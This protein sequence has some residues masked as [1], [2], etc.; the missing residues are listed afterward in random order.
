LDSMLMQGF[1]LQRG[2][3]TGISPFVPREMAQP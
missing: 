3:K 1:F 2:C